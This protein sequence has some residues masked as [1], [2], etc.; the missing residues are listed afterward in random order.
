MSENKTLARPYAK[1]IFGLAVEHDQTAAWAAVLAFCAKIAQ[2]PAVVDMLKNPQ[3]S[4]EK[5][6]QFFIEITEEAMKESVHSLFCFQS[7]FH[8]LGYADRL[9][10]LPALTLM[11][12]E[13]LREMQKTVKVKVCSAHALTAPQVAGLQAALKRRLASEI[14]ID[15]EVDETLLGGAVIYAGDTV[16]D[17][18]V[19]GKLSSLQEALG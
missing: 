1:A 15:T 7:V 2:H 17:G 9:N 19:R 5:R 14:M 16:I 10:L 4:R 18:S 13:I 8:F 3:Y 12:D 11:Y 6:V